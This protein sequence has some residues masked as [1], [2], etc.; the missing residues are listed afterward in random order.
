MPISFLGKSIAESLDR[1]GFKGLLEETLLQEQNKNPFK[2]KGPIF[3]MKGF[4]Y[5]G[6][7]YSSIFL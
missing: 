2:M 3:K 7:P 5:L 6:R 1:K 4:V